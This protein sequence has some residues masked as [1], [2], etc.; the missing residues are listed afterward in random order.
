MKNS[1][2]TTDAPTQSQPKASHEVAQSAI[3][4]EAGET[5]TDGD[6]IYLDLDTILDTRMG[7]LG[8]L[9]NDLAVR[10]LNS[11]KYH[12]RTV[13]E[14]EG[15]SREAFKEA[16]AARDIETLRYSVLT[17]VVFFLRRLIKDSLIS[18][19]I[20][21]KAEK[22]SFTLNVYPYNFDDEGLVEMLIGCMR[23]HTYSTST[24]RIVSIPDEELTPEFCAA[25]FQIM[26]RYDWVNWASKHKTYYETKG[27][28][29]MAVVVPEIFFDNAPTAEEIVELQLKKQN[30]FSMTEEIVAAMFRLKH[31]P[32]S[33]F[34]IHENITKESAG[35]LVARASVTEA[36]IEEYLSKNYPKATLV[37]DN[38]LPEVDLSPAFEL[39]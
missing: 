11:G 30:P 12:K 29:Q 37:P 36:D 5:Q 27:T 17:N 35:E 28:P 21:G 13:D 39:L 19:V 1:E 25:N 32:I 24:V 4:G 6:N 9:D 2:Q 14:F 7:T 31:M 3:L 16:Y 34:S 18:S 15:I 20:H 38:P 26:L 10:T 8:K 33:L 22:L 23:F